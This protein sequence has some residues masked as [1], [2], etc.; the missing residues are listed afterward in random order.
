MVGWRVTRWGGLVV[1]LALALTGCGGSSSP[2]AWHSGPGVTGS[3]TLTVHLL[4]DGLAPAFSQINLLLQG[5]ELQVNG[6]WVPVPLDALQLTDGVIPAVQP[7]D[8]L[9]LTAASPALA[10]SVPWPAGNYALMRL[11]FA[12]GKGNSVQLSADSTGASYPLTPPAAIVSGMG[13]P[14]AFAV[15]AGSNTDFWIAMDVASVIS[16]DPANP[17]QY[18]FNP[19]PVRGYDRAATGTISGTLAPATTVPPAAEQVTLAGV[20]V[21]A[22][23]LEPAAVNGSMLAFR[24]VQTDANGAYSLDLLPLGHSWCVV[25]QPILAAQPPAA[26]QVY[27]AAT[28]QGIALGLAPANVGVSDLQFLPAG[29]T[30]ALNGTFSES[31][32][33]GELDVVDLVQSFAFAGV[34]V[35]FVVQSAPVLAAAASA[36]GGFAFPY[37]VPGS[38]QAVLNRY[39]DSPSTG[40]LNQRSVT[41]PF[42]I[43]PGQIT[44][45]GF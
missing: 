2:P 15:Q 44:V 13:L 31:P 6:A 35:P 45:I 18:L 1:T 14:G 42:V 16:A 32:A 30:G 27:L 19:G 36:P 10:T 24:T 43:T 17:G 41:A 40:V 26:A 29:A 28:G 23:L 4:A 38:Y 7:M 11:T 12:M 25:S 37:V 39:S 20:P 21:T 3:G 5:L 22:Q 8:V 33:P 34:E 9:G